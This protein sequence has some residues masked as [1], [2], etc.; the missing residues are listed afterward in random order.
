MP[1]VKRIDGYDI[2]D[3]EARE[4]ITTLTG[5]LATAKQDSATAKTDSATAKS[6]ASNNA[7]EI[8]GLKTRVSNLEQ[9]EHL[10]FIYDE[11][12]EEIKFE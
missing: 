3:A 6:Q 9:K 4:S 10:T 1:Y 7:T 5:E 11:A 12:N 8:S 2:K